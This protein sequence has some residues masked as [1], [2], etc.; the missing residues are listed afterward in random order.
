MNPKT[1]RILG[2][3]FGHVLFWGWNL[4]FLSLLTFGFAPIVLGD[5][6]VA[7]WVG[8]VP[9]SITLPALILV[10]LPLP[11]MVI[12]GWKLRSDPGRLLTLFYGVQTPLM[13]M[14]LV[15]IFAIGPLSLP[16]V[17]AMAVF[18]LSTFGLLRTVLHGFEEQSATA[19][20]LRQVAGAAS[21]L[22]GLW[23]GTVLG[24]YA[25]C[26]TGGFVRILWEEA[27]RVDILQL[28][29]GGL[30]IA[31]FLVN[32]LVMALYPIAMVGI[33]LRAWQVVH[34]ATTARLGAPRAWGITAA[35]LATA[36]ALFVASSFQPQGAAFELA[37]AA[38]APEATD[39]DRQAVLDR[40]RGVREGL[41]AARTGPDRLFE[42]DPDGE[43]IAHMYRDLLPFGAEVVP[44]VAWTTL[45]SPFLYHRVREGWARTSRR[46]S[47]PVDGRDAS[48]AYAALFDEPMDRAERE[49]LLASAH[50]TWSWEDAQASLLDIG[51]QRVHLDQQTVDI[52]PDGDVA[53]VTIHDVYRSRTWSQ[54]EIL[55][56]FV[57][58]EGAAVTGLWMGPVD[59]RGAAFQHVLAPRGAAQEVYEAEVSRRVDP[60][61]LEQVGPRQ[62]RLRAFPVL[63]REGEA[64]DVWSITSEGPELHLWLE[65]VVP[66]QGDRYPLPEAVEVRNLF[67]D[68]DTERSDGAD[69]WLPAS[70]PAIDGPLAAH[71]AIVSGWEVTATPAAPRRQT[72][73]ATAVLIDGTFSMGERRASLR[74]ALDALDA[75]G[76]VELWCTREAAVVR[77]PDFDPDTALFFGSVSVDQQLLDWDPDAD[78]RVVLTDGG[79]YELGLSR[80]REIH[81]EAPLWLVHLDG[82]FPAAYGDTVLD[83]LA[84]TGGGAVGSIDELADRS[85]PAWFDGWRWTFRPTEAPAT[86]TPFTALA[87][88]AL[89]G[90]LD[91]TAEEHDLAFFDAVHDVAREADVVTQYSSMLVLVNER[92]LKALADAEARGDRFEREVLTSE[93]QDMSSVPEP[94]TWLLLGLGG[95]A[96]GAGSRR[97]RAVSP[98]TAS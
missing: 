33:S 54:E 93:V 83:A 61:L 13:V 80:T 18:S 29:E 2:L 40:E 98:R 55:L 45:M 42:S 32:M 86:D 68:A 70:M 95:L 10:A 41:V 60:A 92:Q 31:F 58:P 79:S 49:T 11:F 76:P 78:R 39:A 8:M 46:S 53:T 9:W 1:L 20:G 34:R 87:G 71:T 25:V 30:F 38:L 94:A 63:P 4:L 22:V 67:W 15:R 47:V 43:H 28:L 59:D 52:A 97:R 88:R 65:V 73:G 56:S 17:L 89:V 44:Q 84:H 27:W 64:G 35:T 23:S 57:L 66:R 19:Q 82:L 16:T 24:I 37:D 3:V 91:R 14:C 77:C 50:A 7:S 74:Q 51:Q 21:L 12:G 85:D 6:L 48:T 75:Q 72:P 90:H 81:G 69:R 96:V 26:L 36:I 62:Y 5:M